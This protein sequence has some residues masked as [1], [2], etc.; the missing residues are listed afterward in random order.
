[1]KGTPGEVRHGTGVEPAYGCQGGPRW[2]SAAPTTSSPD[3][4]QGTEVGSHSYETSLHLL[5]ED[6]CLPRRLQRQREARGWRWPGARAGR[7]RCTSEPAQS[8]P[9]PPSTRLIVSTVNF[10]GNS[11]YVVFQDQVGDQGSQGWTARSRAASGGDDRQL[12]EKNP[13]LLLYVVWWWEMRVRSGEERK[14]ES[15]SMVARSQE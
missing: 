10:L 4:V 13:M 5:H 12:T 7:T 8:R 3:V 2:R 14:G 1:M 11:G 15:S 9:A 6:S